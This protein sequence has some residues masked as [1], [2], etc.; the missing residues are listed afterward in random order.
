VNILAIGAHPDDIE[1]G[2]GGTLLKASRNGHN[3]Y[4]Y[5]LTRGG[6]AGQVIRR[7]NELVNSAK[8]IGA[9]ILWIDNYEDSRVYLTVELINSIELFIKKTKADIVYTHS[10]QDNHHDHRSIAQATLEAGRFIPNIFGYENPSTRNFN[11]TMYYDIT[12]TIDAKLLL[13]KMHKSQ[14][15]KVFLNSNSVRGLSEHRAIQTR[16]D[17][18][19]VNVEAFEVMKITFEKDLTLLKTRKINN[20][21]LNTPKHVIEFIIKE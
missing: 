2:C 14:E 19:I 5:T 17:E 13:I 20:D 9:T 8:S 11:P 1:L 4:M 7:A 10:L 12:D 6:S 21:K 16:L 18:K 15:S 3:V